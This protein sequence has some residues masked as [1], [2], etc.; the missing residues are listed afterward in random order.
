MDFLCAICFTD[1]YTAAADR[2]QLAHLPTL[3]LYVFKMSASGT[4]A[5]SFT[6]ERLCGIF[7]EVKNIHINICLL[8][9]HYIEE[10]E[11]KPE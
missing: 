11:E 2:K 1:N 7:I 9:L 8:S 3:W 6:T 10:M 5:I 4:Q